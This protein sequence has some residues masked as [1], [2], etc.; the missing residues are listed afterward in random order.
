ML[1]DF[2]DRMK[3]HENVEA[4]RRLNVSLPIY[5][6]IDGRGFSKFTRDMERPYDIRMSRAM[7]ETTRTLV[8]RT[9]ARIGYTQSDEI[10]LVFLAEEGSDVLFGGRV[11]KL[12]SI[13]A[14]MTTAAFTAQILA[15]PDFA[16]YADRQPH[17]DCRVFQLPSRTEAA[18]AF[19]WRE[20]DAVKNSVS[21]TARSLFSHRALQNKGQREMREMMF[22]KGVDHRDYPAF[23][24]R[25]TFLRRRTIWRELV[26]AERLA[27]PE[28][29][30]PP[31]ET[32]FA[33]TVI[34]E[35]DMP[36]FNRVENREAVIFDGADPI[37]V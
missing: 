31:I 23:F 35:I 18:N 13:L 33:R 36:D 10:S 7:I 27:I 28:A 30:R 17:F 12:T 32:L 24:Q 19:L 1:D 14:G 3:A 22:E 21:M 37:I 26:E 16:H 11:Q 6:R 29:H 5:A 8:D 34:E 15:N 4:Q 20:R 9:H 25:G 2:G